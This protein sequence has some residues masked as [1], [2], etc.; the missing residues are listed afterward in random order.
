MEPI[1]LKPIYKNY[2]WGGD[3][4]SKLYNKG[5]N[6]KS[7]AESWEVSNNDKGISK[8]KG[9][10]S[11]LSELYSDIE[12]RV[13]IFGT[14]CEKIEKFPLLIKLIDA[15]ENLSIQV[16]TDNKS[17]NEFGDYK[18]NEAWYILECKK[19]A[20]IVCGLKEKAKKKAKNI[21]EKKILEQL[22]YLKVKK[23]DI[24]HIKSGIV[25]ALMGGIV[26]YEIQQNSTSTYRIYDWNRN[27]SDRKLQ[28]E[29][30]KKAIK[31]KKAKIKHIDTNRNSQILL[32]T[33]YFILERLCI[34]GIKRQKS[35]ITSFIIYTVIEGR[36]NIIYKD[37]QY[38]L[39][40]GDTVLI[41]SCLGTF[42]IEGK[43]KILKS[44]IK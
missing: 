40:N 15:A 16:H 13:N 32:N 33:K 29:K 36:G 38:N 42:Y 8:I 20:K 35:K 10:T 2:V 30:A 44:Y 39:N 11:D 34:N 1:F 9:Q 17:G 24:I 12:I 25:H 23:G 5:K 37:K 19:N 4:L 41:P 6:L 3:K 43:L 22:K 7:I 27:N 14:A 26:A 18:K 31:N 28:I 21:D